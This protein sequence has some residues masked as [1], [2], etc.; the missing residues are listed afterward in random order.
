MT[1]NQQQIT[2]N[3]SPTT[4][5][6]KS[7]SESLTGLII[8]SKPYFRLLWQNKWKL[9]AFNF[10]ILLLTLFYLLFFTKPYY[11]STV[12]ILPSYGNKSSEMLSQM[13]GLA[14]MAGV[15]VGKTD[16]TQIYQ[17]LL[18]SETILSDVIYAKYQTQEFDKPVNLIEYFELEPDKSLSKDLQQ[19]KMF[20]TLFKDFSKARVT[21]DLDRMTK[22]LNV[23]VA[24]PESKLSADVANNLAKALDN[25][26]TNQRQNFASVQRKYLESRIFQV[27][28]TLSLSEEK[29][30]S[31]RKS[32]RLI[33]QSP[34]LQLEQAR[35]MRSVEIQQTVYGELLKQL[36]IIK[37]EEVKNTPVVN[38]KE[39]AKEPILK[40]GP[41]R[42]M[43][44]IVILF[45]SVLLSV[46]YFMGKG[47]I[48]KF[49]VV[50]KS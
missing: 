27:K 10:L 5:K 34:E 3:Q 19:R 12:S 16:P 47:S 46:V 45:F 13:S 2:N 48:S 8:K 6:E 14:A 42:M 18:T 43:T 20:L 9:A 28:D 26:I 21:T 30:L 4:D 44:L 31:F 41:K 35:L 17:V 38:I 50:L 36:E 33:S 39:Y 23:S 1:D 22:I 32:N 29:L 40:E 7:F 24:M 11:K 49:L 37:L 15:D 25:Y